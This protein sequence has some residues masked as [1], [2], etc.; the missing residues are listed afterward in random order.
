[1]PCRNFLMNRIALFLLIAV[2]AESG[3]RAAPAGLPKEVQAVLQGRCV[4]CHGGKAVKGRLNLATPAGLARGGRS[5]A[6][7]RPGKTAA[8]LLWQRVQDDEMPPETPLAAEERRV[9]QEWIEAGAPGLPAD[10]GTHWAFVPPRRPALP[11][12]RQNGLRNT[13]DHFIA[14]A[15]EEKKLTL[16]PEADRLTLLRRVAFDLTGLPPSPEEINAFLADAAPG[17][18]ERMVGRYL[19]SPHYGERWGKF[20]LDAAGYADSNGYFNADSDRPLAW[21]YR[22]YVIRSF[23]SDKPFDQFVR[24]QIA[25]D[26]MAGYKPGEPVSPEKAELLTATHFLRNAPDGSG[27]SDG[28]PDE[29][30]TDRM[31]VL[32]GNL[33][34]A[35]NT[36][37]G[38]TIQ[39]AR[40]HEHKFEPI[41]HEEYYRL[42]AILYP[43]YCPDRWVKP[44]DRIV[45]T[46]SRQQ[47]EEH[48]RQT[49][50]VD[51]QVQALQA[52]LATLAAPYRERLIEER[53]GGIEAPLRE[54]VLAAVRAPNDRR[55]P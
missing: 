3:A 54:A 15:L 48:R 14:A 44:N 31:T 49:A 39:C 12:A 35:M 47:I 26:E 37:L 4:E 6:A 38:I 46:A 9:L 25:G 34:V 32:E 17:A 42:Q 55:T 24:E 29:V 36:L 30:L 19:A 40:C 20:W 10:A 11:A 13:V 45:T 27:E 52:A 18:Y 21:K 41:A 1:M 53:L 43:V 50:W 28:N 8:S 5:G 22:D 16:S 7:V 2:H 51:R 23:N 33:Q